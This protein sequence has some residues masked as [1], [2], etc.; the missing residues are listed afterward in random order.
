[1]SVNVTGA[2]PTEPQLLEGGAEGQEP[3]KL[4]ARPLLMEA[5]SATMWYLQILSAQRLLS[6]LVT[7]IE[8]IL[9]FEGNIIN[10]PSIFTLDFVVLSY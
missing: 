5:G 4:K 10:I 9:F 7:C 2:G 8:A 3:L 6:P 1:M